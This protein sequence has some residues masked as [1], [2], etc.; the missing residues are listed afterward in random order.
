MTDAK[1]VIPPIA[2]EMPVPATENAAS[3]SPRLTL[4]TYDALLLMLV[5]IWGTNFVVLKLATSLIPSPVFNTARFVMGT[6]SLGVLL[7]FSG[8]RFTLPRKEWGVV[9]YLSFIS[10]VCYQTLFLYALQYTTVANSSLINT[11][12]PV[13]LVLTNALRGKDRIGRGGVI[14]ALLAFAG[15]GLVIITTHAGGFALSGQSVI[16]DLAML[17]AGCI[18]VWSVLASKAPIERLPPLPFVFWHGV[19]ICVFQAMLALPSLSSFEWSRFEGRVW[20]MAFYA[21]VVAFSFGSLIWNRSIRNI[22]P[23][24]TAIYINLQPIVSAVAGAI[25]LG[26]PLTVIL[27]VGTV[28]VLSGVALVKRG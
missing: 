2:P 24:R 6:I 3:P 14:G 12:A 7:L 21:G 26:E 22:G 1:T 16:G 17:A 28:M 23:S 11:A 8:Q 15:V 19:W 20:L 18:W 4:S 10:A 13:L 25:L 9:I 27:A 5:G